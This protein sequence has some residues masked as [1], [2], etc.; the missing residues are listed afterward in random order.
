MTLHSRGRQ[1]CVHICACGAMHVCPDYDR[2][3]VAQPNAPYTCPACELDALD[4][5]LTRLER[6]RKDVPREPQQAI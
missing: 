3:V 4:E 5:Y 6:D 2:C 1:S